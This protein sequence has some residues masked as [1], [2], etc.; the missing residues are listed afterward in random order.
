MTYPWLHLID[1][2]WPRFVAKLDTSRGPCGCWLW[3]GAKTRG[4]GNKVWYG[5]FHVGRVDGVDYKVNAHIFIAA[6]IGE[7][8]PGMH[9]DHECLNT[10]C[11]NPFHCETVTPTENSLRRLRD[12]AR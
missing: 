1:A 4:K 8:Q 3:L 6:A 7:A 10:L 5:K 2:A 12:Y 11:V 9:R